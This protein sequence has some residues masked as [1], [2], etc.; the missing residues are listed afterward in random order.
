MAD[1]KKEL[2]DIKNAVYGREVRSSIHDGIK[3]I[4]EESEESKHKAEEAHEITQ[5]LL[6]ET[7]DSAALEANF[8]QRLNDEIENLQPEWTG[9]KNDVTAQLAQTD[10]FRRFESPINRREPGLLISWVDDDGH[11]LVYDRFKPI[12]I[13]YGI[14]I[15]SSLITNRLSGHSSY[16]NKEQRDELQ[17][18]GMEFISH[19]HFHDMNH[20]PDDM[21]EE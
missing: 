7:F 10:D 18:L 8:E 3:K 16:L 13:D 2:N 15:T 19:S 14:P 5:D 12:L 9:F 11:S 17:S 4:N 1:I 21:T 6:D 20:R